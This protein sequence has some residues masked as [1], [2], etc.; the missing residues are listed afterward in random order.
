MEGFM[1]KRAKLRFGGWVEWAREETD[2]LDFVN[3]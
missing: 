3:F 2:N 1:V